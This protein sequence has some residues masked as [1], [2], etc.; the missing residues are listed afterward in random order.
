MNLGFESARSSIKMSE[1]NEATPSPRRN[2]LIWI[3]LVVVG[4]ILFVFLSGER[5]D[6]PANLKNS[7]TPVA[8]SVE[9]AMT[10]EAD[11]AEVVAGTIDRGLLVPPGMRARQYIE[12][13]RTAGKPYPL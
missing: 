4:L 11:A 2:P 8:A 5:G 1:H 10:Q 13:L 12:Q 3:V 9:G 6:V 7:Q